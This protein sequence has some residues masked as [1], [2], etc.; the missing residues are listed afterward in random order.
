MLVNA[1]MESE[2]LGDRVRTALPDRAEDVKSVELLSLTSWADLTPA[3]AIGCRPQ[4]GRRPPP[5]IDISRQ[6]SI[7]LQ[8]PEPRADW[9]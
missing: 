3:T 7:D 8:G 9:V 4:G 5:T 2:T 1:G 6:M